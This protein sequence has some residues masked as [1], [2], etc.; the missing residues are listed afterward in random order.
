MYQKE[1]IREVAAAADILRVVESRVQLKS[2]GKYFKGLCPFHNEKNPS[3]TVSFERGTYH[4]F[5]CGAHGDAISFTMQTQHYTFIEA[6]QSLAQRFG[7]H[8]PKM[9]RGKGFK[10]EHTSIYDCLEQTAFFYKKCLAGAT[11]KSQIKRYLHQRGLKAEVIKKFMVGYAPIGKNNLKSALDQFKLKKLSTA[12]LMGE[13]QYGTYAFFQDRLMFAI[14]NVDG[15]VIGFGGRALTTAQQPKYLN[16][17]QTPLYHKSRVLYGLYEGLAAIR[18]QQSIILVEG[19]TD[20]LRMHEAGFLNT[21]ATCGT[22]L[23]AEHVQVLKN[24]QIKKLTL[25]LDADLAGIE[26]AVKACKLCIHSGLNAEVAF[27]PKDQDPDSFLNQ[28]PAAELQQR[29]DKA[30]EAYVFLVKIAKR[31]ADR[32]ENIEQKR[33][34]YM[35][36]VSFCQSIRD[37]YR[38][39]ALKQAII[40]IFQVN[41]NL[42]TPVPYKIIPDT[43]IPMMLQFKNLEK[44]NIYEFLLLRCLLKNP[45]FIFV[46]KDYITPENFLNSKLS[47]VYQA[48]IQLDQDD[49]QKVKCWKWLLAE[50]TDLLEYLLLDESTTIEGTPTKEQ[51]LICALEVLKRNLEH[52]LQKQPSKAVFELSTANIFKLKKELKATAATIH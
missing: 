48:I 44:N 32:A 50:H 27:L 20:V 7:V 21:V 43:D 33:F 24:R 5:G 40:Q 22:A 23:T 41:F 16:T 15:Q 34:F 19:Y 45:P 6:V 18:E 1:K 38:Q 13:N 26:A 30:I 28:H 35:E 2:A 46:V 3:F 42:K 31:K 4:C 51:V 9:Q 37:K 11:E 29:L 14:R 8:L 52:Q 39:Q 10:A 49:L 25:L 12:G 36:L 47:N 17:K